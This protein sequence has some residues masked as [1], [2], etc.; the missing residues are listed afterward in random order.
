MQI[1]TTYKGTK[2]GVFGIYCGFKPEGLEV[3]EE[4]PVYYADEGKIFVKNGE[5]FNA[6][7]L[8]EGEKIEDYEEVEEEAE[9]EEEIV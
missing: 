5:K 7:V 1:K 9:E 3:T 4:I 8:Q 2:D 6:I